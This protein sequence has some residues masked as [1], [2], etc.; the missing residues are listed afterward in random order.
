[1]PSETELEVQMSLIDKILNG[2]FRA[3]A[4]DPDGVVYIGGQAVPG[5]PKRSSGCVSLA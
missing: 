2:E 3:V 5:A 4:L 1:M